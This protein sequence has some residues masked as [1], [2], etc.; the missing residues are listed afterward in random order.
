MANFTA[1]PA[2]LVVPTSGSWFGNDGSWST[3]VQRPVLLFGGLIDP[4]CRF[5]LAVGNPQQQFAVLPAT[6]IPNIWVPIADDCRALNLTDC[7]SK[8]GVSPFN[9]ADSPGFQNNLSSTWDS[10]GTF[11]LGQ[12]AF[13]GYTGNGAFGYDT[14]SLIRGDASQTVT[15]NDTAVT[16][17]A[18]PNFWL[19]QL[20]LGNRAM[21]L[22]PDDQ[23]SSFLTNL[24]KNGTIPSLSYAYTAGAPYRST[25]IPASLTLGG[26]DAGRAT[27]P[28][29]ITLN[30][31]DD[32][33]LTL[34]IQSISVA[35]TPTGDNVTLLSTPLLA[36]I[37][38]SITDLW[39]PTPICDAF[40]AALGLQYNAQLNRYLL[41]SAN[42]SALQ[43]LSPTFTFTL[44]AQLASGPTLTLTIPYPAFDLQASAPIV[45]DPLPYFPIRRA[46]N[47]SQYL[48]GRVFLQEAYLVVDY[49]RNWFNVSQ[50]NYSAGGQQP[51][52]DIQTILPTDLPPS[53]GSP[54][55]SNS[56][57]DLSAGAIAGIVIGALA[58]LALLLAALWLFHLKPRRAKRYELEGTAARPGAVDTSPHKGEEIMSAEIAE[59]GGG[60]ER[61]VE[62]A[63]GQGVYPVETEGREKVAYELATPVG[64][65][66]A[67]FE[68]LRAGNVAR[69]REGNIER[70]R[71]EEMDGRR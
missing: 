41:S 47:D 42:H 71:I 35:N 21:N 58:A 17:Y 3:C 40:A 32:R 37:D 39:L 14:V 22:G 16:A 26:Y 33:P 46:A 57:P 2:A 30:D 60:G 61:T 53:S 50:A 20:G 29:Q 43:S 18:S 51:S 24:K 52:V 25:K 62:M 19:G 70:D 13:L 56:S 10:I 27:S 59:L 8:R 65:L 55:P 69:E 6:N 11:K 9:N 66:E 54:P 4:V 63:G 15:N 38:S 1:L 64:E 36:P 48:I 67:P 34:A 23:P 68:G 49:E 12:D 28:L 7:G 31:D 5:T 44:G 45:A